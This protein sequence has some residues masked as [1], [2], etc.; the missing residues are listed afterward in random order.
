[1]SLTSLR[2]TVQALALSTVEAIGSRA[3]K[4]R[5]FYLSFQSFESAYRQVISPDR[6]YI[7]QNFL[8][9]RSF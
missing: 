3:T 4:R 1:M 2:Q 7:P 5:I 9:A 6:G 8:Q